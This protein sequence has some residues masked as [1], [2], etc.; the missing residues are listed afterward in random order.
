MLLVAAL[1]AQGCVRP[2]DLVIDAAAPTVPV[3]ANLEPDA[4]PLPAPI[5]ARPIDS[6]GGV[7]AADAQADTATDP[8]AP[9]AQ[10]DAPV[11]AAHDV[12]PETSCPAAGC[13][14]DACQVCTAGKCGLSMAPV[15][16]ASACGPDGE[17][18]CRKVGAS[19]DRRPGQLEICRW[20]GASSTDCGTGSVHTVI[21]RDAQY[22]IWTPFGSPFALSQPGA[23]FAPPGACITQTVNL[24]T[25]ASF[26][27]CRAYGAT[28]CEKITYA[29]S[30]TRYD[31]CRWRDVSEAQCGTVNGPGPPPAMNRGIWTA[32]GTPF[33]V[34]NPGAVQEGNGA[35]I[36]QV[37][38]L[39]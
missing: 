35:C 3:D 25:T 30:G 39:P 16:M 31:L 22:G 14:G 23:V 7:D 2:R 18:V 15:C 1:A 6:G 37:T 26:D 21:T 10:R 4:D 24:C 8:R 19:C 12:P 20:A 27:K 33:D 13:P 32:R 38:N 5:D 34:N 9:D 17:T 29:P 36:T 11:D 28:T